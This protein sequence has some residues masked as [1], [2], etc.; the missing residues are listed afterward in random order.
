M[1][2]GIRHVSVI[3]LNSIILSLK[4]YRKKIS[5]SLFPPNVISLNELN[6]RGM[7]FGPDIDIP[8]ATFLFF[9]R[10]QRQRNQ[11][12]KWKLNTNCEAKID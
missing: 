2:Y 4:I 6:L 9:V 8:I 3:S 11:N 7:L 12:G 10:R 1:V 5:T